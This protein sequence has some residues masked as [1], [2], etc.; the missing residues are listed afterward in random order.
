MKIREERA[1]RKLLKERGASTAQIQRLADETAHPRFNGIVNASMLTAQLSGLE[2]V[3][4]IR[5]ERDLAA[6]LA[7]LLPRI[8][9]YVSN[10]REIASLI[11]LAGARIRVALTAR[12]D[13]PEISATET[14]KDGQ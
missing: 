5:E 4:K 10:L 13:S 6:A 14:A 1:L 9:H 11:E 3:T 12:E 7:A 2:L 8:P